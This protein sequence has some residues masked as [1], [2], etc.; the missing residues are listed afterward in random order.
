MIPRR[1]LLRTAALGVGAIAATGAGITWQL[2]GPRTLGATIRS[3]ARLPEPFILPGAVPSTLAPERVDA[4]G[5]HYRIVQ[6]RAVREI[7]PGYRT[8]I[9]GYNGEFPGP[10]IRARSG[11]PALVTHRNELAVP[12]VAHLH[13][14]H[15]PAESDGYPTDYVHP[16]QERLYTYPHQQAAATLW[17]H[18]HRMDFSGP[19]VWRG[20]A[21][22]HLIGDEEEDGLGLPSGERDL[23]LLLCD[24][25]FD[26]AGQ[27]VYPAVDPT[28]QHSPGVTG[29]YMQ[30][31]Q[32]DVVL[33]NGVPWPRY[34][35]A[36]VRYRLR[37]LNGSNARVY[38]LRFDGPHRTAPGFVQ[39][40]SDGGLL[41][42]PQHLDALDM[43]PGERVDTIVDLTGY[44][45]G[46]E[47]TVV[48]DLGEGRTVEVL[49]L[50]VTRTEPDTSRIPDHLAR[51]E[52][53]DPKS[54]VRRRDLHFHM[55]EMPQMTG[56]SGD[57][58][59]K[60]W[61]I[62]DRPFDPDRTDLTVRLGEWEIWR[63]TANF[64]HPVHVHLNPF[65]VLSRNG[66]EPLP[67]DRGWKDTVHLPAGQALELAIR[68]TGYT[69]RFMLHCHNLEHEDMAMMAN[70]AVT[71]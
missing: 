27:L 24:R 56:M 70:L 3:A 52:R 64:N 39:I 59:A 5:D 47:V 40:G 9:W 37:W 21:G 8:E 55:G 54:A 35:V 15:T 67:S 17:Y 50:R 23:P 69:G 16:S 60:G 41:D 6:R 2:S 58:E 53:F 34:D 12:T 44:R 38:R 13:G 11:R 68:F 30:G 10:T 33:V 32:G 48:N 66:R 46:D 31:V 7:L 25:A 62:D 42:A 61:L 51:I 18:D 20:L 4:A 43:A 63:L 45:P 14:G 65:Q 26:A 1:R 22:F 49:R 19:S 28:A 29:D 57:S 36:S 71:Q